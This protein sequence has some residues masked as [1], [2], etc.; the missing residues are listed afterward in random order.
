[1][2]SAVEIRNFRG[3]QRGTLEG[4][5]PLTVLVGPNASGKSTILDALLIGANPVPGYAVGQVGIRRRDV[6]SGRWLFWKSHADT[7]PEISVTTHGGEVRHCALTL[8]PSSPNDR[9]RITCRV[10]DGVDAWCDP[11][12]VVV[13]PDNHYEYETWSRALADVPEIALYEGKLSRIETPLHKLFTKTREQGRREEVKAIVDV[14][15]PGVLDIEILAPGDSPVVYFTFD[16]Y[17]APVAT[18]GDGVETL[19]RLCFALASRPSG[20]VLVEEPELHKHPGALH[21][22]AMAILAALRR[23]IQIIF[24]THSLEL[25][26][27]ILAET[28]DGAE[29]DKLSV[30]RVRL[31]D[32][33]LK[34]HRLAGSEIAFARTTIEDDLR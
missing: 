5:T 17:S 25:I 32:G 1:V 19:L 15:I 8:D 3:I 23:G 24:S 30:H 26:D 16:D 28:R 2:I 29:L 9:S 31:T 34:S 18:A 33:W 7:E 21:Q 11:I 22:C 10:R 4:L 27:A 12:L 13:G 20:V 14:V 6:E